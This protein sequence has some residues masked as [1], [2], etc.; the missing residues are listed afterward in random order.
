MAVNSSRPIKA[1]INEFIFFLGVIIGFNILPKVLSDVQKPDN[2]GT[3]Y[4]VMVV[5]AVLAMVF[6]Y[7]KSNSWPSI[8]FDAVIIGVLGAVMFDCG[9][10][11]FHF[12]DLIMDLYNA[13]ILVLIVVVLASGVVQFVVSLLAGVLIA[14]ALGPVL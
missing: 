8:A 10:L 5:S 4:L 6:W 2:M 11:Y 13:I 1:A 12:N 3:W 14:L 7:A 9:F